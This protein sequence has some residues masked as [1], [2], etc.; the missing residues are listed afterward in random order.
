MD[1]D[2]DGDRDGDVVGGGGKEW[3]MDVQ[4]RS[5]A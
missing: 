5:W 2:A 4:R 1:A 3:M